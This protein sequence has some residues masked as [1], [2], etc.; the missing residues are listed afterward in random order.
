[1][2]NITRISW[3]VAATLGAALPAIAAPNC[4]GN[5][6]KDVRVVVRDDGCTYVS[7]LGSKK[8]KVQLGKVGKDGGKFAVINTILPGRTLRYT[9]M[10]KC[11]DLYLG[12][13]YANY[14]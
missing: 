12:G 13:E 14:E 6:C 5:A 10:G 7:N 9:L 11:F 4:S 8:V 2:R 1:M 3:I